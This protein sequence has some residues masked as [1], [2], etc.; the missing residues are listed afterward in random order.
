MVEVLGIGGL[1]GPPGKPPDRARGSLRTKSAVFEATDGVK[2]SA[3]ASQAAA[4]QQESEIRQQK[5]EEVKA[6]LEEGT[7][8]LQA[9][10]LLVAARISPYVG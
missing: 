9:T 1:N 4:A 2:I 5:I 8:K 7:Y 10:V 6:R 3:A